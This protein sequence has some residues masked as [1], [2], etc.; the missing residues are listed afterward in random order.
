[1]ARS[2]LTYVLI[3]P[4]RNEEA[5][6]EKT[7]ASVARQSVPP[8]RWVI[9]SDGSTDHTEEIAA[10][11]AASHPWITVVA[12]PKRT[13]RDFSEKVA[14][15]NAGFDVVRSLPFDIV[16][17]LDADLSFVSDYFEFLLGKF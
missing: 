15:F 14:A 1:M 7:I 12:R 9:V 4:A 5:H 11:A 8:L 6:L 13:H 10:R 2:A 16:G 3:S 17:S